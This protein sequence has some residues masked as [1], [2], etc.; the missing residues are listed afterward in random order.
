M[1]RLTWKTLDPEEGQEKYEEYFQRLEK[2]EGHHRQ[3]S[4][5]KIKKSIRQGSEKEMCGLMVENLREL[6]TE[7]W[8]KRSAHREEGVQSER[9][10][11]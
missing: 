5:R 9:T 6:E 10:K 11:R 7:R 2:E 8:Q 1:S 4:E 3:E